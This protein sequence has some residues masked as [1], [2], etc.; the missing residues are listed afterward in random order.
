MDYRFADTITE[1]K[2]IDKLNALKNPVTFWDNV[3]KLTKNVHSDHVMHSWESL[4]DQRFDELLTGVEN[5]R[6]D[7][8]PKKMEDGRIKFV[9]H[10]YDDAWNEVFEKN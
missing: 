9:K 2:R 8:I 4:S 6:T 7:Y 1:C 10:Y 5:V 3:R